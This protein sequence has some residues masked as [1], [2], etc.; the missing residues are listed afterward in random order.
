[1]RVIVV[2]PSSRRAALRGRL[3]EDMEVLAE[4]STVAEARRMGEVDAYLLV[5]QITSDADARQ[6]VRFREPLVVPV[7]ESV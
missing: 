7:T 4:A 2:G 6:I 5:P 1:M 3:P